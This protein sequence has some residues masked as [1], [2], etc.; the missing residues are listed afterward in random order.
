MKSKWALGYSAV[1]LVGLGLSFFIYQKSTADYNTALEKYQKTS[2]E[3][4]KLA[5][6]KIEM[7]LSQIH[8][9]LRTISFLPSV[10]GIARHGENLNDDG[11]QSIQQIYNNLAS[12]V[13]VSEVYVVP[14]DLD[15][16][17]IDEV[18][19]KPQEPILMF[20]AIHFDPSLEKKAEE[21]E[22][23]A[24]EHLEEVETYEYKLLKTQMAWLSGNYSNL[25]NF[26]IADLPMISG[27]EVITCDNSTYAK[28]RIDADRSGVMFSVPFYD[29]DYQLKGAI[30][31][32][33]LTNAF[34]DLM[35]ESNAVLL[36]TGYNYKAF[37]KTTGQEK[38]SNEWVVQN[39]PDPALLFS[40]VLPVEAGD[41]RSPWTLW[42][43][44]PD[45]KFFDSG[46]IKAV[47]GFQYAGYGFAFFLSALG[48]VFLFVI[49]RSFAL[50][51]KNN[52]ELEEKLRERM[53]EINRL[54]QEQQEQKAAAE[55]QK[56]QAM[57]ALAQTFESRTQG[58][59][60]NVAQATRRMLGVSE[61]M[62]MSSVVVSDKVTEAA[63]ASYQT[64]SNI[65]IISAAAEELKASFSEIG[66]QVS[67][68]TQ[69]VN[70]SVRKA[71]TADAAAEQLGLATRNIAEVVGIIEDLA[72]QIN[73]LALNATIEA[74][75]AGEAG[76][77]FVVVANE[78]KN[79]ATQTTRATSDISGKIIEI[80]ASSKQVADVLNDLK[81]AIDNINQY[82]GGIASAVEEQ[83][84]VTKEI[85]MNMS[86]GA[87]GTETISQYM[88]EVSALSVESREE[89]GQAVAAI[90]D[91]SQQSDMLEAAIKGFLQEIRQG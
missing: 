75:R 10:R 16:D 42:V 3:D 4:S 22:D 9:N 83:S 35:P 45:S 85:A 41:P 69:I 44:Y 82:S 87:T 36:N 46:D 12:N 7:A 54:A 68:S 15:S 91:L 2:L 64:S 52:A 8:Q 17:K 60:T 67:R 59:I 26:K 65:Q 84:A 47:R 38:T 53:S 40:A 43:G 77:G 21:P 57:F 90:K 80:Q 55:V 76:R 28:T 56:K 25:K 62:Q 34:K 32:V 24:V 71:G 78:V 29:K 73:L 39:K 30:S 18:T 20:D 61:A 49:Q 31:T 6:K 88:K 89:A 37:P 86:H 72:E 5:A 19:H 13:S 81:V 50:V 74:A 23:P 79:L 11:R 33:L 1:I 58:I 63:A 70:E 51:H 27:Q 66:T 48:M 14:V